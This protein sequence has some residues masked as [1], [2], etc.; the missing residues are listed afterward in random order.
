MPVSGVQKGQAGCDWKGPTGD[1]ATGH[2][3]A[4]PAQCGVG[5]AAGCPGPAAP[6]ADPELE[7]S[8]LAANQER[9][10]LDLFSG[11]G[12]VAKR[13]RELG[14]MVITLDVSPKHKPDIL[15]NILRWK[16]QQRF[17]PGYFDLI[18]SSPP[19]EEYSQ[20]KT[21]AE[22]DLGYSD[23]CV[24]KTLEIVK[25]FQPKMWWLENPRNGLLKNR[26][27]MKN[28][29]FVDVDYCQFSDW[30]YKKPTRIWGSISVVGWAHK[31]CDG[32][33]CPNLVPGEKGVPVH[34]ESLGGNHVRFTTEK[35]GR[36]P[37][38]LV[39]YLLGIPDSNS[40]SGEGVPRASGEAAGAA[41]PAGH[42]PEGGPHGV[43]G[44]RNPEPVVGGG[45]VQAGGT[46]NSTS[47][48]VEVKPYHRLGSHHFRLDSVSHK[49]EE[50][51][52]VLL[53]K[54]F[55]PDGDETRLKILIDTGAQVNLVRK[56]L[57][58][59][60]L[61]KPASEKLSLR[62]A[63][64]Q[65]MEGGDKQVEISLG[66]RQV[67]RGETMAELSWI[68][69]TFV[70]ADIHVDA[71]L[72]YP[73]LVENKLGVFPHLK[74]LASMDPELCLLFGLRKQKLQANSQEQIAVQQS[75]DFG[76]WRRGKNR[77]KQWRQKC[78]V[79]TAS[80]NFGEDMAMQLGKMRLHIDNVEKGIYS[81]DFLQDAE[82]EIVGNQLAK[83]ENA[84]AVNGIVITPNDA[85]LPD[86]W[87]AD[88]LEDLRKKIHADFDGTALREDLIPDPPVR[89]RYGYAFIPLQ[90]NAVPER[91]KP[92]QLYGER[93][94]A[95]RKIVD[96]WLEKKFIERPTKGNVEW[97][98]AA[99]PVPKKSSTFPW[100]GVAD[101]R[102]PNKH[103]RRCSYPLPCIE[104]ILIRQGAKQIFSILDLRQAFH[105][106]PMDPE[107]RHITCTHTPYGIFQWRVNVMGL[108]NAAIQFQMMVDDRLEPV[109][110]IAD[111]YIDD[112]IVGT[113]VGEGEDLIA[114][115]DKDLRRVLQLLEK[116][117]LIADV[118]KC[119]FF[120][121]EVNF[122]GHILSNGTRRPA[123]GR[124]SAIENWEVPRTIH[125]LR[126]F[127]GFTNYY[128]SYVKGYTD[129]IARL[130]D[131]LKVPRSIGKKGSKAKIPWGPEDD[132][133][134]QE[135][136]NR[137][138]SSLILQRV[139]PDKP[140][141]LRVDASG[142]AVG[143]VLEQMVDGD[144]LPTQ[145][146]VLNKKTVPVAFM[147][148]KLLQ[149]QRN[150][151]PREQETYAIILAL[152]K[153]ESWIG[154]QPILVLT[155]HKALEHWTHEVLDTPSGPLGRR[156]RWHQ[157]LSKYD[158]TVGYVPGKENTIADILSRWAYPASQV[159]RDVSIHGSEQD[160]IGM[161]ELIQQENE[162]ES[163]CQYRVVKIHNP[164]IVRNLWVRGVGNKRLSPGGEGTPSQP[165]AKRFSFKQPQRASG[166]QDAREGRGNPPAPPGRKAGEGGGG[167]L[168]VAGED[169]E[170]SGQ[171]DG[172]QAGPGRGTRPPT[173]ADEQAESDAEPGDL[174]SDQD[175]D[176]AGADNEEG[177]PEFLT[178]PQMEIC[179]WGDQYRIC[180]FFGEPWD[181]IHNDP[182]DWPEGYQ[183]I[184]GKL[185]LA[186]RLC[187]PYTLQ[188]AYIRQY[189][190]FLG[191]PGPEKLWKRLQIM[192]EFANLGDAFSYA[193]AVNQLC[194]ICQACQ[195]P[196]R[197]KGPIVHCPIPPKAMESVAIDIFNMPATTSENQNF[198]CMACCVDRHSG[199]IVAIPLQYAGLTGPKLAQAMLKNAW[200]PFGI[201][202][203][204]TSDQGSQ[205]ISSWWNTMCAR[206]GIRQAFSQAYHHQANGRAERA[207]QQ[208]ME[209]LRQLNAE[210]NINWVEMLPAV[211]DR[212]HDL[213]GE[214]GL[215]PYQILFGRERSLGNLPYQPNGECSDAVEFFDNIA[216]NDRV[217]A[218]ILNGKHAN[219]ADRINSERVRPPHFN[220]GEKVWYLRPEDSG[221][222][223]DTRWLGPGKII[224]KV[225]ENSY[226]V[227]LSND[228]ITDAHATFLKRHN[229][230]TVKGKGLPLY[231]FQRT[232]REAPTSPDDWEVDRVVDHRLDRQG[233]W[234]FKVLWKGVTAKEVTWEPVSYFFPGHVPDLVAYCQTKGLEPPVMQFL[235]RDEASSSS[236]L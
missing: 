98:S 16:Y 229:A 135:I 50:L 235:A 125:E 216:E 129:V 85:K 31:V 74:A 208:L 41:T 220:P 178:V 122:C 196:A 67:F 101:M 89:G 34:R 168:P 54:A 139:N 198:D 25:Y 231:Y 124:L 176:G 186:G 73:W 53:V 225:G 106:Q 116:E 38:A 104:D 160:D 137:L 95:L 234:F 195:R 183:L 213:P 77:R 223:L 167:P 188:R 5:G 97:L 226:R 194:E 212:Y 109:R 121:P 127:L 131:K 48:A 62:T 165:P 218:D 6:E 58:S 164:P 32:K 158:L 150:W 63:N 221:G 105:Q 39:D 148:R 99:F 170:G 163:S 82:L 210:Q 36:I 61:L 100:R 71:I 64:G 133:A 209:K 181:F 146:D 147:S 92:F 78:N 140:F 55:L 136:K 94:E 23:K 24:R 138:C 3:R 204:I 107:S 153:W 126:A 46:A 203:L 91:Q 111:V 141:V 2:A 152:Q 207:G 154:L 103:T 236:Q 222:K 42:P 60:W 205:F 156:S 227:R 197:L 1:R 15:V 149:S 7:S 75:D 28:I 108:K 20:A 37:V 26:P 72:S 185:Y 30:G 159:Q 211:L 70:D 161:G 192:C 9:R 224:S 172:L 115:H 215:S 27:F 214:S 206:L 33:T 151:V 219:I 44:P 13:L 114:A 88:R 117:Q 18:V 180:P 113:R 93:L 19:C 162:V 143:A 175:G 177:L 179:S 217:V 96:Q 134:F 199:W 128:S 174:D 112:I 29:P 232:A 90:E 120:I 17:P 191:H 169:S 45:P 110:D 86:G 11:T 171:G 182:A 51:Q 119:Q 157:I 40:V 4:R 12:S 81:Q 66:F 43:G 84:R 228:H 35:K 87:D 193:K 76:P 69:A 59:D 230:D 190:D 8:F 201:P 22:R 144:N 145:Q 102:L 166:S 155:D 187:I 233:R 57:I 49:S 56:G 79:N 184:Q 130:Q 83:A 80:W 10:A 68:P 47:G 202:S 14:F 21:T 65:V 123:P 132:V 189:H 200:R 52:L 142:Y 173:D 118:S